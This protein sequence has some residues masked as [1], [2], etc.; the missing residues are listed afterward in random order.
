MQAVGVRFK[1]AG[2]IYNY[3]P[4][5][6]DLKSGDDV[7]VETAR[8]VEYGT[9]V[10]EKRAITE[11]DIRGELK[12]IIRLA[13]EED[14]I[15][16]QENKKMAKDAL[17]ICKIKIKEHGLDMRLVDCEYTFNHQKIIFYFT[18]DERIDF[19]E[20]VRDLAYIFKIR[21]ELR[22]IG[23]RDEAKFLGGLGPCGQPL[24]CRRFM[25]NFEPVSI[26]MAKDQSLSL[27]PSK[28]S[29]ACGRLMCCLRHE[30]CIYEENLKEMPDIGAYVITPE[31]EGTIIETNTLL[32]EAK[33]RIKTV[34]GLE[35]VVTYKIEDLKIRK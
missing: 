23:V 7:I 34:E 26:N 17:E 8:G 22:Q 10:V 13:D 9:I 24:C 2:K 16:Y 18:A 30:Q 27:N 3:N 31:G 5:D 19:R 11:E 20:L 14:K 32:K 25:E 4:L 15:H 29:G 21:I 33:A 28:I 6:M 12:P 35:D 1:R